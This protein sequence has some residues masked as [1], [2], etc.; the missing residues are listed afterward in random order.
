[1]QGLLEKETSLLLL[2]WTEAQDHT[3]ILE[4]KRGCKALLIERGRFNDIHPTAKI[5]EKAILCGW[6]YI[7]EGTVIGKSK[8][9]NHCNIGRRCIIGDNVNMQ[10]GTVL[11]DDTVVGDNT[12]F[13]G[14]VMT[15]D[16][17]YPSTGPQ[18]RKPCRI[19][20]NVI[21]GIKCTLVSCNIGDNAV[22]GAH[23]LVLQDVPAGQVWKGSP[24]RYLYDRDTYDQRKGEWEKRY[25]NRID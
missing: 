11:N 23:S 9:D 5:A 19:G 13:A 10:Y 15:A 20:N 8:I 7:G 18:I 24:A 3:K 2:L 14:G 22:V 25:A 21:L 1:V 17:I 6:I 4:G 12:F 16:E